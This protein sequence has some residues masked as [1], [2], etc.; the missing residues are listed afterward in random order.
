MV[1]VVSQTQESFFRSQLGAV[2]CKV[3]L[4]FIENISFCQP[5][6]SL[7]LQLNLRNFDMQANCIG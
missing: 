3:S 7:E 1:S 4:G 6:A 5:S 2:L